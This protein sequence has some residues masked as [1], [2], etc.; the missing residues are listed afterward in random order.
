M[1]RRPIPINLFDIPVF[2]SWDQWFLLTAGDYSQGQFNTMT[3][4]WGMLGVMWN[5]AVAQ[6]VVR[7]TRYTYSF[8]EKYPDFT[9]CAFPE[10]YR[11]TLSILGTRSGRAG[12]KIKESGLTPIACQKV[13]AP[14]FDE[15]ELVLECRKAYF[16]DFEPAHF[17]A[18]YIA[19]E[20]DNDYHRSYLGEILNVEGTDAYRRA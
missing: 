2:R 5:K 16:D 14:A 17:L 13:A 3:V 11:S 18:D 19:G 4:S 12:N 7:P 6:V 20:Y 15:A 9:L 10:E 8:I 1:K